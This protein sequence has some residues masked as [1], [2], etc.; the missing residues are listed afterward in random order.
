[1]VYWLGNRISKLVPVTTLFFRG[2]WIHWVL[3]SLDATF[4]PNSTPAKLGQ[5]FLFLGGVPIDSGT[6]Y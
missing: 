6:G 2:F 1:M 3:N 5:K 4:E